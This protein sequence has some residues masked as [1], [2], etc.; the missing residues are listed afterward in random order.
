MNIPSI[1]D[2]LYRTQTGEYC[3]NKDW[4]IRRIP[5]SVNQILDKYGLRGVCDQDN[6]VNTD[7][8]LA[9]RFF[10]AAREHA[11]HLG[12]YCIDTERIVMVNEEELDTALDSAPAE[13]LVGK[14]EDA[15]LLKARQPADPYPMKISASLAI[16]NT[17]AAFPLLLEG[18]ARQKEVDLLGGGSL[19]SIDG[20]EIL[21][22]TPW[23]TLVG[24]RHA[25][26]HV[27]ARRRAGRPGMGGIGVYSAVTEY[28]QFDGYG[29]PGTFP[30]TDLALI[31]FPSELKIDYRTLH[32][33][34]HTMS[35]GGYLKAAS[36]GM[37]GGMSGPPEG[38]A[39]TSMAAA[40]LS[41]PILQNTAGGGQSYDVRY[42]ANV[43]RE[44]LWVLSIVSQALSRN[45][46][47]IIDP[48]VNEVSGAG[49]EKLLFEIAAG[50]GVVAASGAS[51]STG[52]RTAGGKLTDYITPLECK[53]TAE[54]AHAASPIEPRE[55][56]EIVKRLLPLYEDTIKTPDLGQSF[57]ELFDLETLEPIPAWLDTYHEVKQRVAGLGIPLE[58]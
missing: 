13:L 25:E 34:V 48:V 28:G 50:I 8:E 3:S 7:M 56:N 23:E 24:R 47:L 42:L 33:V 29:M 49:T 46:H 43:N 54:V 4:D 6:P 37:I 51:L 52:P 45:T 35:A 18:I 9:D 21:S 30:P 53:F 14:G 58:N 2:I 39:L 22:G 31:L 1:A 55:M 44:G 36:N 16:A 10:L 41:Y 38:A 40:L 20:H 15:C 32:K 27:E 12:L 19:I 57:Q 26:L 5:S 11:L 17:E